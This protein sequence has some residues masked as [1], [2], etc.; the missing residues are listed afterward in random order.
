MGVMTNRS[1]WSLSNPSLNFRLLDNFGLKQHWNSRL[2]QPP[3]RWLVGTPFI[4]SLLSETPSSSLTL[5]PWDVCHPSSS[6]PTAPHVGFTK[7]CR[8]DTRMCASLEQDHRGLGPGRT[9]DKILRGKWILR[10][11]CYSWEDKNFVHL[12]RILIRRRIRRI[13]YWW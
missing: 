3:S 7:R 5:P 12:R 9:S 10:K 11:L 13:L 8:E 2:A 6:S 1:S 4:F